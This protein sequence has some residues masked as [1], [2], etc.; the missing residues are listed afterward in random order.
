MSE[1]DWNAAKYHAVSDPQVRWGRAVV[2]KLGQLGLRG[3]EAIVDAGCGT[4]RLTA[5]LLDRW[6]GARVIAVDASP[7]MLD[8]AKGHL[9]R[10][11]DRV[12]FVCADLQTWFDEGCA[13][14][15]FSTATFHWIKDHPKLFGNVHRCLRA[16]GW[17]CA[18]C[19]GG[20][21]LAVQHGRSER[22]M[23]SEPFARFFADWTDP[24]EFASAEV[25]RQ[26]LVDAGFVRVDTSV[27]P[28]PV[29]FSEADA[30]R[31]FVTTVIFR[32][33]L[34]RLPDDALRAEFVERLTEMA[35]RD[36]P[37]YCLD[38]CRLNL[39]GQRV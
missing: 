19:G 28:A 1:R 37:P 33:H 27:E 22:V 38:Y 6:P 21:N 26:R 20:P 11:G 18:Q 17:L 16:G 36:T 24:W 10:F 9:A 5:E 29:V 34:A 8:I 32:A 3:D 12:A 14:V 7:S 25:G 13:D 39:L 15:V 31:D 35:G 30:F 4:G 23:R 2:A